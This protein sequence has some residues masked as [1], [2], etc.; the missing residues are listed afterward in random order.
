[1]LLQ[2]SQPES[3]IPGPGG[4]GREKRR[5]FL[6]APKRSSGIPSPSSSTPVLP[7]EA[8]VLPLVKQPVAQGRESP[9]D[10]PV[11][12]KEVIPGA[13]KLTVG[14]R[15]L[16]SGV[17]PGI[18]RFVGKTHIA[19]GFWCGIEL[20]DASG[21]HDGEVDGT[22]YFT[23]KPF[24]GIF[25]P[26]DKVDPDESYRSPAREKTPQVEEKKA[27]AKHEEKPVSETEKKS[28]DNESSKIPAPP[29]SQI[30]RLTGIPR[31]GSGSQERGVVKST[32]ADGIKESGSRIAT[33]SKRSSYIQ[34]ANSGSH[35]GLN[36]TFVLDGK[37]T[38]RRSSEDSDE[39]ALL[40]QTFS[41]G[42]EKHLQSDSRQYLNITFNKDNPAASAPTSN[43]PDV[44]S[45]TSPSPPR[46][47]VG[48]AITGS[49]NQTQNAQDIASNLASDIISSSVASDVS[50]GLMEPDI[51][52]E[53]TNLLEGILSER[54]GPSTSESDVSL[55]GNSSTLEDTSVATVNEVI[56]GPGL[57]STPLHGADLK[58]FVEE[59]GETLSDNCSDA[60]SVKSAGEKSTAAHI[61][62]TLAR[63]LAAAGAGGDESAQR[64]DSSSS[65]GGVSAVRADLLQEEG[66]NGVSPEVSQVLEWDY[67]HDAFDG[68]LLLEKCHDGMSTST[69]DS[70]SEASADHGAAGVLADKGGPDLDGPAQDGDEAHPFE[71]NEDGFESI[72]N[73]EDF[74]LGMSKETHH[75]M[76]DSGI[77]EKGF[78]EPLTDA[79]SKRKSV[80][81]DSKVNVVDV[82]AAEGDSGAT[83][84]RRRAADA[85]LQKDLME[86]HA[87]Q[88]R[89]LS[90]VSTTSAD[91]GKCETSVCS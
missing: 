39:N 62:Q 53:E 64:K 88:E 4:G 21:L 20:F 15:I 84:E 54:V 85:T 67:D 91:T 74:P 38:T 58:K 71:E 80:E 47:T 28:P 3:K 23:C 77:S 52:A 87:K 59:N 19:P 86:G 27:E 83:V 55:S 56:P 26:L 68:K 18:L 13:E 90:L 73:I 41:C 89:P 5:S 66:S 49:L 22:R 11:V 45:S 24:R 2:A 61:K 57:T 16:I 79:A 8:P 34:D 33:F 75:M 76:T 48:R 14:K 7:N 82:P 81:F 32:S 36:S 51:I 17:K 46:E 78:L 25:A 30:A 60:D 10:E 63:T 42:V 40:N 9:K 65:V 1:M 35:T 70:C 12:V 43:L 50:L 37:Q 72:D 29:R 6:P 44:V 31:I 69:S